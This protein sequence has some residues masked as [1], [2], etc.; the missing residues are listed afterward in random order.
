MAARLAGVTL[1]NDKRI[2]VALTYIYGIGLPLS[3]R[4]LQALK[5][6]LNIR[7]KD[8]T[9]AQVNDIKSYIATQDIAIEGDLRRAVLA[10]VK[11]LKEINSYRGNRHSRHLPVHGQSTKTNNRTVRGNVRKTMGSGRRNAAE[12]T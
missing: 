9:E 1:P 2:E 7:S 4:I 11:R 12:K 10:N 8:L 5:I 6:D 3:Q